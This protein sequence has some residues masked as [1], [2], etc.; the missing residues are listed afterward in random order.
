MNGKV[1]DF[2]MAN[3]WWVYAVEEDLSCFVIQN[4]FLK[5]END[6]TVTVQKWRQNGNVLVALGSQFWHILSEK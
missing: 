1:K 5:T 6:S 4:E 3:M 2:F